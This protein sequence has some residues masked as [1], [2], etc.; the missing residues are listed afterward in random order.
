MR[1]VRDRS[2]GE[3]GGRPIGREILEVA[4]NE[5]SRVLSEI[6]VRLHASC[7]GPANVQLN[8]HELRV[9]VL[10]LQVI[11]AR[12]SQA[13]EFHVMVVIAE[14]LPEPS[15]RPPSL[16]HRGTDGLPRSTIS[17]KRHHTSLTRLFR[18]VPHRDGNKSSMAVRLSS[19]SYLISDL[20]SVRF[21]HRTG[22]SCPSAREDAQSRPLRNFSRPLELT[23]WV[24]STGLAIP[25][26]RATLPSRSF[27]ARALT[28]QGAP[29]RVRA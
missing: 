3:I 14:R 21:P 4:G 12:R 22:G 7:F 15:K 25:R 5:S 24:R 23:G 1:H 9:G 18:E 8:A 10:Q 20:S 28:G 2:A 17:Q 29:R 6:V 26:Q 19:P 16:L 27:P 13:R 11:G